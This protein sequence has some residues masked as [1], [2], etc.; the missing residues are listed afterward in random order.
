MRLRDDEVR[1]IPPKINID[2]HL[3]QIAKAWN[4]FKKPYLK[5]GAQSPTKDALLKFATDIDDLHGMK[6]DPPTR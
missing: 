6:F 2:V 5:P 3:G 4:K 1:R